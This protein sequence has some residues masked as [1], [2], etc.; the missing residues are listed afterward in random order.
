MRLI[1]ADALWMD[2]IHRMDYCDDILEMIEAMP[3]V[4]PEQK[5]I[6]CWKEM[7]EEGQICIVCDKGVIGIDKFIGH[8]IPYNWTT[9][10]GNYE[11]WLPL[12]E[13]YQEEGESYAM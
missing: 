8:G 9:Y 6:P 2:V 7:P 4:E 13:P 1:D 3:T 12:P 11:A 10:V 5:W